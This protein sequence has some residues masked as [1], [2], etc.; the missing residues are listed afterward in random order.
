MSLPVTTVQR[1]S[2]IATTGWAGITAR[3]AWTLVSNG[4]KVTP[5]VLRDARDHVLYHLNP[6]SLLPHAEDQAG[7]LT[8]RFVR[9]AKGKHTEEEWPQD[10]A[11]QLSPRWRQALD[12]SLSPLTEAIFR[13]HYADGRPLEQL[14]KMFQVDRIALEGSRGGLREV[15][16]QAALSDDVPLETWSPKRIDRLLCRLAAFSLGPCPPLS[17][18]M[19]GSEREHQRTCARCDRTLRLLR[20]GVLSEGDLLPPGLETRP[21]HRAHVM[22]VHFHPDARHC[23]KKLMAETDLAT[24]PVDDDLLL[25]DYSRPEEARGLLILAAEVASPHRD[26]LRS[27]VLEGPGRWS[28]YGLIGPLVALARDAVQSRTWA[29]LDEHG[30][31]PEPLAT[32][33]P[34]RRWWAAAAALAVVTLLAASSV[35]NAPAAT[36]VHPAQADFTRARGG[37]WV[38]FD[39]PET[40]LLTVIRAEGSDLAVVHASELAADKIHFAVGDGSYLLHTMGD[41]VLLVSSATPV[42]DLPT[43]L[44]AAEGTSNPLLDLAHRIEARVPD[45]D[46]HLQQLP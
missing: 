9:R 5:A 30:E 14:E 10:G 33:P 11:M 8:E 7:V 29:T 3:V 18:L 21:Q 17:R 26:H 36:A 31:L 15:I 12:H 13:Q 20:A 4:V 27:A 40:A 28:R 37:Y 2:D 43:L 32:P 6:C 42:P 34:A 39:L 45:A 44:S 1:R 16:R 22:A 23:R 19:A 38:G 41:G 35:Q 25:V 24:F 46:I